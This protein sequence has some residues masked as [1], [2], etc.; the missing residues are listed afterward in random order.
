MHSRCTALQQQWGQQQPLPNDLEPPLPSA[1]A[2]RI[3]ESQRQLGQ[4]AARTE[5]LSESLKVV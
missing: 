3:A 2:L 4:L 5:D 1:L